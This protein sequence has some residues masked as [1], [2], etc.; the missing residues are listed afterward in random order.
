MFNK[1][2]NP[3][4]FSRNHKKKRKSFTLL[5]KIENP[6]HFSPKMTKI[7]VFQKRQKSL[8]LLN[9]IVRTMEIK[10]AI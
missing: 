9:V 6:L 4:H 8:I 3:S 10:N 5:T 1:F 2:E 7:S